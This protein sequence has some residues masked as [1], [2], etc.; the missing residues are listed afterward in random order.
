MKYLCYTFRY[1]SEES[2]S[3]F[4]ALSGSRSKSECKI[5]DVLLKMLYDR[6]V[7][8]STDWFEVDREFVSSCIGED[9][10]LELERFCEAVTEKYNSSDK[11]KEYG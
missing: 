9:K 3:V 5:R 10:T 2:Y 7:E 11:D 6:K 4:I 8:P 1:G